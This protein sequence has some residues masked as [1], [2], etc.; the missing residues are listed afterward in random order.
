MSSQLSRRSWFARLRAWPHTRPALQAVASVGLISAL[1]FVAARHDLVGV[2]RQ[3]EPVALA[4]AFLL[5]I[6]SY[7]LNGFRWQILLKR[8][9]IVERLSRLIGLYFVGAFCSQFLPSAAGGDAVRI[10]EVARSSGRPAAALLATMQERLLGLGMTILVGLLATCYFLPLLPGEMRLAAVVVQICAVVGVGML[11]YPQPFATLFV[12]YVERLRAG[13]QPD[14]FLRRPIVDK[15]LGIV[16]HVRQV[17]VFSPGELAGLIVLAGTAVLLGVGMVTQTGRALGVDIGFR[18]FCLVVPLVWI[19]RMLPIS[20]NGIGVGEGAIVF[21]L[22]LF[23][24]STERAVA[25]ALVALGVQTA[26]ALPGGLLLSVRIL[27][28]N[29]A[30]AAGQP[31]TLPL[32]FDQDSSASLPGVNRHAA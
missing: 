15:L 32:A 17:P 25:V 13:T 7:S 21:L 16:E 4:Q 5:G 8:V 26:L 24:V 10:Y 28:G 23:G 20:L 11:L 1:V 12:R 31:A 18:A 14:S 29:A 22:G 27:R 30:R 19:I 6:I 3:T 2:L 9:G